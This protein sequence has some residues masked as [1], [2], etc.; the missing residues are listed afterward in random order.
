MTVPSGPTATS[1]AGGANVTGSYSNG[2]ACTRP[3]APREPEDAPPGQAR[4]ELAQRRP[5][6][7]GVVEPDLQRRAQGLSHGQ[8]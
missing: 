8:E 4:H 3:S 1:S 2:G 6:R 5:E 7:A